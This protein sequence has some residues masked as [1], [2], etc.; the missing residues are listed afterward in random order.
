MWRGEDNKFWRVFELFVGFWL[1]VLHD[2]WEMCDKYVTKV[3]QLCEKCVI[4]PS[5]HFVSPKNKISAPKASTFS[6]QKP[7]SSSAVIA[8]ATHL[9]TLRRLCAPLEPLIVQTQNYWIEH[10]YDLQKLRFTAQCSPRAVAMI[11]SPLPR[12][13]SNLNLDLYSRWT[14][15]NLEANYNV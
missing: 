12:Q 2:L 10:F 3:C 5:N 13:I 8:R 6:A 7:Q 14:S 11:Q 1:Q 4:F 9:A 15:A